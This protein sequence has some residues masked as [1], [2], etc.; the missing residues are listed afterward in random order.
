MF[1]VISL[2]SQCLYRFCNWASAWVNCTNLKDDRRSSQLLW[3]KLKYFWGYT[4][5]TFV[6]FYA[7]FQYTS[8]TM[9][10][11]N[12]TPR[13]TTTYGDTICLSQIKSSLPIQNNK[14]VS[15]FSAKHN[16]IRRYGFPK[17]PASSLSV[18]RWHALCLLMLNEAN[19]LF[20]SK[21]CHMALRSE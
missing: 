5:T 20:H 1:Y 21:R 15:K 17:L 8:A 14:N 18:R 10:N 6:I 16:T 12:P 9:N 13:C 4:D 2:L 3:F 7:Y 11:L 19:V